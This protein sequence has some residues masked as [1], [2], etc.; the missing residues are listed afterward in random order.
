[1]DV[2]Q[3]R[4]DFPILDKKI[5]GKPLIYFDNAAT[6]HKPRQVLQTIQKFY[7]TYNAN[8][9]RSPH[10]LGMEAT[11]LYEQA[12]DNV[13]R[14][15]GAQNAQEIIFVRNCTEAINLVAYS[16]T[17]AGSWRHG[18]QRGDEVVVTVMEHHSNLVPWQMACQRSGATLKVVDMR[19]DGT[20][21]LKKL[22][23]AIHSCTRLVC[24][25]HVSNV[26]GTINPVQEIGRLAHEVGALY[27][28]DGAQSA[29]HM[30]VD[31]REIGCDF[32]ACSGHKMMA[33]MG[34]GVLY[35]RQELLAE[36]APF[37]CGGEMIADVTRYSASWNRLPWK[38]E[39]GT[40][41]VCAGIT[42]GG[43][44]DLRSSLQLEGAIDYLQRI[45]MTEIRAHEKRL[46]QQ[47]LDGLQRI[48]GIQVYG[49][50]D[51]NT[52]AG[53]IAF[54][55]E[56]CSAHLVADLLN[57]EGIAVRSGGHCAYPLA[58][59]LGVESTVRVSFYVYNTQD[60]IDRFL[61]V[62]EDAIEHRLV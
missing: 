58:H 25:T 31:V 6:T 7:Q 43:A 13:A 19:D 11:E 36:M 55:V 54:D 15:I 22:A 35:G 50:P 27:L 41:N 17:N 2:E 32:F 38:F 59:R 30:P 12:H 46:T 56:G 51:V 10:T 20:L 18:L 3:I 60:E 62:L 39:A 52:R 1:M 29:P 26:L 4:A 48:K 37:L 8:I 9:H 45:G 40:A 57:D 61:G 47:A 5:N 44:T 53:V 34:I 16:L 23:E 21:D 42:L 49:P 28:V 14:Y 24:C 33:P